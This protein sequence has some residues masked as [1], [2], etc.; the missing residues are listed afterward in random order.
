[1]FAAYDDQL[2]VERSVLQA[3]HI[4]GII[5]MDEIPKTTLD[6][7]KNGFPVLPTIAVDQEGGTVQRYTVEG[8]LPGAAQMAS[9]YTL[10]QAYQLYLK[11][12]QYLKSIGITTNFS[13]VLDVMSRAPSPLPGRMYSS[14]P[15]VV[16]DYALQAVQAAQDAGIQPVIKHFPGLGSATANTDYSAATTDVLAVLTTRDVLPYKELVD[17]AP[18]VM[19]SNAVVPDLTNGQPAIWSPEAVSLLRSYGYADSVVYSDSLTAAAIPGR[20]DDA[21]VAAWKA[22]IDVVVIVQAKDETSLLGAYITSI[23]SRI[24]TALTSGEISKHDVAASVLRILDQKG[25]NPCDR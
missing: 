7:F 21:S 22:G 2:A 15:Q 23:T 13:P 19:V 16:K 25:V 17:T 3:A 18:D 11:D 4:G 24:E 5:V 12:A 1:M 8:R 10:D 6:E 20:L 9:E 14:D